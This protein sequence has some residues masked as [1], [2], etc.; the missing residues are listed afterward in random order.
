YQQVPAET[1]PKS[2]WYDLSQIGVRSVSDALL[3]TKR[4]LARLRDDAGILDLSDRS[5]L[6]PLQLLW[7]RKVLENSEEWEKGIETGKAVVGYPSI[8]RNVHGVT[9]DGQYYLFYA[10]HDASSEIGVA[11]PPP[12]DGT[13]RKPPK[14]SRGART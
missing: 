13:F 14:S 7:D 3:L 10:I 12:T 1:S 8:V 11:T 6:P 2:R 5:C 4:D 9:P